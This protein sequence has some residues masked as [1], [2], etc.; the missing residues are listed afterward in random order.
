MRICPHCGCGLDPEKGK[1]RSVAQLKRFFAVLRAMFSH[2]PDGAEFKPES[3]E[4]LRKYVIAK[5]GHRES[6][7]IA[8]PET[9]GEPGVTRLIAVAFESAFKWA[10]NYAFVRPH[11]EGGLVRI[12]KAKSIAFPA[13]G[14]AEFSKLNDDVEAVYKAETGL[15][16]DQVLKEEEH[17]A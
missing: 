4:H 5:A 6:T 15:D 14:P 2:W 3:E 8:I 11:P 10:G 9:E 13:M 16:P 17:A 12:Y 1:P 7:D